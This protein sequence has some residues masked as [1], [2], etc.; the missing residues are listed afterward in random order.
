MEQLCIQSY[1]ALDYP[2]HLYC[3][4][5]L[6]GVPAGTTICDGREILPA[7]EIFSHRSGSE[8][9]SP[10][11][12]ADCFRYKLLLERGGGGATQMRSV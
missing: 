5:P 11:A 7:E 4:N 9:G 12:F 1:L 8:E 6:E 3:Y 2:V 10:A